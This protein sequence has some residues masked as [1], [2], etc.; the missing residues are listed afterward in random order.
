MTDLPTRKPI[1][2]A[3]YDYSTPGAYFITVCINDRKPIFWNVGAAICRPNLSKSGS[4]VET[5]ILQIPEHYPVVSV[6][7]YCVMP[8]HIHMILYINTDENGRQVAAPTLQNR[9]YPIN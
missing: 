2:I 4:V 5:A 9:T 8:D 6:D 3:D 1:R 7:K